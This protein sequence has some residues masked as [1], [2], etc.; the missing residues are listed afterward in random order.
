MNVKVKRGADGV[1]EC[2]LYFGRSIDGKPRRSYKRF[3]EAKSQEEAQKLADDWAANLTVAGRTVKSARLVDLLED[4]TIH[5]EIGGV[6]PNTVKSYRLFTKYIAKYLKSANARDL[7]A[8]DFNDFQDVLGKS[9]DEGGQGLS[10]SSI[11]AVHYF[12]C[13]AYRYFVSSGICDTNPIA[14]VDKPSPSHREALALVEWD[15]EDMNKKVENAISGEW[16]TKDD[17][18]LAVYAFAAWLALGT[19]MRVGEICAVRLIDIDERL[20]SIHVCGNV[21]EEAGKKPYRSTSTKGRR[22]R[23][24]SITESVIAFIKSFVKRQKAFLGRFNAHTPI[25]TVDGSYMRPTT[26][27]R[28]FSGIRDACG[29]PRE[30]TFHSLRHTHATWLIANGCDLKTLSERL[31]HAD[32]ATTLR[33]YAHCMP[34]RDAAAAQLFEQIRKRASG[35]KDRE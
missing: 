19:G 33:N 34:G 30:I 6:S 13:G 11:L 8:I 26:V 9:K 7:G 31:G 16:A 18:R 3:P 28:G 2:R 10:A 23:Q 14:E 5:R 32:E 25:V 22:S 12:L 29:L 4:Y 20:S 17:H 1:F 15:Y 24:V 35:V 21:I 27:S